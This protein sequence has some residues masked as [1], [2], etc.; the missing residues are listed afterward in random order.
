MTCDD[1]GRGMRQRGLSVCRFPVAVSCAVRTR[2]L[3]KEAAMPVRGRCRPQVRRLQSPAMQEAG[4]RQ[5][6]CQEN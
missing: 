2:I 4:C 5:K 6:D 1:Q 3:G